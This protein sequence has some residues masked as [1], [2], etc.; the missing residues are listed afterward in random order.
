MGEGE[1]LGHRENRR[2]LEA[3]EGAAQRSYRSLGGYIKR[4]SPEECRG[5]SPGCSDEEAAPPSNR[6]REKA[7]V[8]DDEEALG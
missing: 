8:G 3:G 2:R 1:N 4:W 5:P 6:G 7:V